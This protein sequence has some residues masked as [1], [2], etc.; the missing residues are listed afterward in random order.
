MNAETVIVGYDGSPSSRVALALAAREASHRGATLRIVHAYVWPVLYATL[1]N[2]PLRS[3]DWRPAEAAYGMLAEMRAR[4]AA[5][6][7]D[8]AIE[9]VVVSGAGG[10]VLVD[11]SE[12][13]AV[14]VVG[15]SGVGGVAGLLAGSV[16][17]HVVAHAHCPVLVTARAETGEHQHICVGVDGGP[18]SINALR[19]GADWAERHA[20]K[21]EV[22]SIDEDGHE[23]HTGQEIEN[24][25]ALVGAAH[26][27]VPISHTRTAGDPYGMLAAHARTADLLVIGVPRPGRASNGLPFTS[28][29]RRLVHAATCPVLVVPGP[30][31]LG[32]STAETL[33][34]SGETAGT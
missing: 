27:A 17:D 10:P 23:S 13:A 11:Q 32:P 18:S 12:G 6:Y 8:L 22:L 14:V 31:V 4:L 19:V 20:A 30:V 33:V 7:P 1:A 16:A 15:R 21:L 24:Q 9:P 26:P 5:D 2:I 3:E 28:I 25:I 34:A 29:G